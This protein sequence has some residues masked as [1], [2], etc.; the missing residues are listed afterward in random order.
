MHKKIFAFENYMENI[1]FFLCIGPLKK[2]GYTEDYE[3]EMAQNSFLD[4][5]CVSF[6]CINF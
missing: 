6:N 3:I 2:F 4:V 5:L 1:G